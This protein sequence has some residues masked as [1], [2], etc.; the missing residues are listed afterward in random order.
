MP[1]PEHIK[2]VRLIS[3]S[4]I[5]EIWEGYDKQLERKVLIKMLHPQLARDEDLRQR[6][7]REARVLASLTHPNIVQIYEYHAS[8]EELFL[9][10]EFVEGGTLRELL[11]KHTVL[12]PA[13]SSSIA[14]GI[15][16]GLHAAHEKGIIH[17]DLKPENILLSERGEVKIADFGLAMV[18]ESP[19]LTLEG[20]L[21]GSPNYMAPE[22]V[23]GEDVTV[24]TDLFALGLMLFEML[25]GHR[26]VEGA[27][28][29]E[30]L[31]KVQNFQLPKFSDYGEKISSDKERVLNKLLNPKPAKRFESAETARRALTEITECIP[32]T[33][34]APELLRDFVSMPRNGET[35]VVSPVPTQ[36]RR[37]RWLLYPVILILLVIFVWA[38]IDVVPRI[39]QLK[40][41]V[42]PL[43]I[44]K[45]T[46]EIDSVIFEELIPDTT[47]QAIAAI[48][49]EPETTIVEEEQKPPATKPH[50]PLPEIVE[51]DTSIIPEPPAIL[52]SVRLRILCHPWAEVVLD[53]RKIGK[54]PFGK[55]IRLTSGNHRILFLNEDFPVVIDTTVTLARGEETLSVNFHDFVG[56]IRI[57][58][59]HPWADI[60]LDGVQVGRTPTS[61]RFFVTLGDNHTVRLKHPDYPAWEEEVFFTKADT[62]P[63][64]KDFMKP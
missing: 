39:F 7:E 35:P 1:L 4:R 30:S 53:G 51:I 29:N 27:T 55:L 17:R 22:Q 10:L 11:Q 8:V 36:T 31:Q 32:T 9:I 38:M 61:E 52:D 19:R 41:K 62:I 33:E 64:Q 58:S 50:V 43:P 56:V 57:V 28:Y 40:D 44:P 23:S 15:L 2:R 46:T 26:L 18:R 47:A 16:T 45:D 24:K 12:P 3:R 21:V 14:A 49:V 63:I 59:V 54:T 13:V 48:I 6:F 34:T 42:D 5:A 60:F 25:T 37:N 20:E